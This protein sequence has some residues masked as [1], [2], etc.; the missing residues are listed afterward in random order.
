[1][2][3]FSLIELLIALA[4]LGLVAAVALPSYN[5][6]ATRAERSGAQADLIRCAQGMERHAAAALHYE[7][8][9]DSDGDGVGDASTGTVSANVCVVSTTRYDVTLTAANAASFV[10]RARPLETDRLV[11]RDGVLELD[12]LGNRR[13]D[14][15]SDGDF[16]DAGERTWRP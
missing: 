9:I 8:A 15:N 4:V 5:A 3:G 14:R 7:R 13:W 12:S 6:F 1:M 16:D 10:L 2:R 11:G